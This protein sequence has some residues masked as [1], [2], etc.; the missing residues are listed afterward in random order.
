MK[1]E[2]GV[3]VYLSP[4]NI[5]RKKIVKVF[6]ENVATKKQFKSVLLQ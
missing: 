3:F 6:E 4:L 5:P 1:F 2:L